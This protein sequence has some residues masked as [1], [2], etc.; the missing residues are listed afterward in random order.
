MGDVYVGSTMRALVCQRGGLLT[1]DEGPVPEPGPREALY[2][3]G[4]QLQAAS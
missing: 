1:L 4:A 3:A 2:C